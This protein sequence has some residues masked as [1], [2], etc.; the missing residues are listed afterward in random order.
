MLGPRQPPRPA[1]TTT[2]PPHLAD[3]RIRPS[4]QK[5]PLLSEN[6]RPPKP[7]LSRT[8]PIPV[9]CLPLL[10]LLPPEGS[11][12]VLQSLMARTPDQTERRRERA[13]GGCPSRRWNPAAQRTTRPRMMTAKTTAPCLRPPPAPDHLAS[14]SQP[15]VKFCGAWSRTP[16]RPKSCGNSQGGWSRW[17]RRRSREGG[18]GE[19]AALEVELLR[20]RRPWRRTLLDLQRKQTKTTSHRAPTTRPRGPFQT[21]LRTRTPVPV[22]QCTHSPSEATRRTRHPTCLLTCPC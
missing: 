19:Q 6:T 21:P 1:Q 3:R 16:H 14:V 12:S 15:T 20:R 22:P 7:E 8:A 17:W 5:L 10:R 13:R 9:Q 18:G 4:P 2:K 11:C